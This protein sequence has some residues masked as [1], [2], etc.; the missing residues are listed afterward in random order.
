MPRARTLDEFR[1]TVS[2][3]RLD[4]YRDVLQE[5]LDLEPRKQRTARLDATQIATLAGVMPGTVTQWKMRTRRGQT[6]YPFLEPSPE[7]YPSKDT[8]VPVDVCMWLDWANKW[9]PLTASREQTR[10]PKTSANA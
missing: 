7:S 3:E 9:P 4:E 8:Y 1:K 2:R 10:G 5:R 6:R